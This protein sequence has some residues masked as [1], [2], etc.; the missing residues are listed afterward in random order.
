MK[1]NPP[2]WPPPAYKEFKIKQDHKE[3][4]IHA[5]SVDPAMQYVLRL[6]PEAYF[7]HIQHPLAPQVIDKGLPIGAYT[8][9]GTYKCDYLYKGIPEPWWWPNPLDPLKPNF[10]MFPYFHPRPFPSSGTLF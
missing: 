8:K 3:R 9:E 4:L 1:K 7:P 10:S 6:D 5:P 2:R